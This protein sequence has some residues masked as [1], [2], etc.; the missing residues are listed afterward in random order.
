[1]GFENEKVIC[2]FCNS[3][4][5]IPYLYGEPTHE[6]YAS[7]KYKIGGCVVGDSSPTHYCN[8]CDEN[9]YRSQEP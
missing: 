3:D 9:I 7:G 4:N 8:D 5:T 6:A 2:P 1:M